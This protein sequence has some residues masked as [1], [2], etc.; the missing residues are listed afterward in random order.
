V[1]PLTPPGRRGSWH[2]YNL[3]RRRLMLLPG[4]LPHNA[5]TEALL[6]VCRSG[7]VIW[8]SDRDHGARTGRALFTNQYD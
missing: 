7:R 4:A 8:P 5:G 6:S 1:T 2:L 3:G